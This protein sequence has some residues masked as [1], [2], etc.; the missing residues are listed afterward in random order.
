MDP[1]QLPQNLPHL[2]VSLHDGG[3]SLPPAAARLRE[4]V[5]ETL[6]D[7]LPDAAGRPIARPVAAR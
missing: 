5:L 1:A 2:A 7:K 4:V 6:A 3:R